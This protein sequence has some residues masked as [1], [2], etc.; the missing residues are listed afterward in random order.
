MKTRTPK[1]LR[2]LRDLRA[3]LAMIKFEHTLFA[4]PFAFLGMI[5]AADGWPA[6]ST[7]G[8][9]VVAMVGARS[10]AMAFNRSGSGTGNARSNTPC[11]T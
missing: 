8:W 10:A 3:T 4:L 5:L 7:V 9:I 11:S 6:W 2:H 1:G